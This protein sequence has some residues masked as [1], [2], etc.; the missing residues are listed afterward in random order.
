MTE[1]ELYRA[2]S[3]FRLWNF[4]PEK[5]VSLRSETNAIACRSVREAFKRKRARDQAL[6][7]ESSNTASDADGNGV[8]HGAATKNGAKEVKEVEV[9][10][11]EEEMKMVDF[12]CSNML[13]VGTGEPFNFPINVT[14]TSVQLFKRF[15]LSHSP[16]DYHPKQIMPSAL[17]LATK[18]EG[19]HTA[20]K[21]FVEKLN[22][23]PG[24][25]KVTAEDVLAPEFILTQGLRFCFDVRHPYRGL[26]GFYL[27]CRIMDQAMKA[28]NLPENFSNQTEEEMRE[29][30]KRETKKT[31]QDF[32][33]DVDHGYGLVR[34]TLNNAALVSDAYFLYTPSQILFGAWY[35]HKP[36]LI[37]Y[38]LDMKLSQNPN[39]PSAQKLWDVINDCT[40]LLEEKEAQIGAVADRAQL[41]RIDKKLYKCRN[42]EKIDLV[43]LN[44]AQK[45][46]AGKEGQLDEQKA[47]KRKMAREK[48]E[49]E[50]D[51]LFGPDLVK[52]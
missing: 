49:K 44:K 41:S 50:G 2:S 22:Q 47:K 31:S 21:I 30:I 14:G 39:S 15:Y 1:D 40:M 51:D 29:N 12:Y 3:Q 46:D 33:A 42:P 27:E 45:R 10:T 25:N 13:N 36:A 16:M 37:K 20:L 28:S 38:Y 23:V 8:S 35:L 34:N 19:H 26:K 32:L 18:T 6:S 11:V 48:S 17:F 5:L 43:G 4:T 52:P 7:A 9:L 24:L